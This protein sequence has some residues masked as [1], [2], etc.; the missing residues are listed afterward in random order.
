MHASTQLPMKKLYYLSQF[1]LI[2]S[3]ERT[4]TT[5]TTESIVSHRYSAHSPLV[6]HLRGNAIR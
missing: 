6:L 3:H 5:P 4:A 2:D 1:P